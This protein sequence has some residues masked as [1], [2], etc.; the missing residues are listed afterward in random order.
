MTS[1]NELLE[2]RSFKLKVTENRMS[3]RSKIKSSPVR[4]REVI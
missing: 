1:V 3:N 4:N 2:V